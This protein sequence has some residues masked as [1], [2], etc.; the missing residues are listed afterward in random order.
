MLH[1]LKLT[2]IAEGVSSEAESAVAWEAGVDGQ[3][4]QWT[5]TLRPDLLG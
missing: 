1:G 4:G 3:T 2:V 5:S